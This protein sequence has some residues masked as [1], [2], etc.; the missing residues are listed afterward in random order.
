[1]SAPVVSIVTSVRDGA[2]TLETSL[3]SVLSQDL[4]EIEL[5]VVD[6]GSRDDSWPRLEAL[7]AR[8]PRVRPLRQDNRGLTLALARACDEARAPFIAR[9]DADDLSLPGRLRRQV[10]RLRARPERAFVS[11]WSRVLGPAD[12]LLLELR[13]PDDDERARQRLE[14]N[15]GP[16]GHGSVM[17]RAE[18][19]R[20]AGGYRAA[21]RYAQD[22]DLW[23]RLVDL[24]GLSYEPD[25][26][27]AFR[28]GLLS[29]SAERRSQQQRLRD[30]AHACRA[31][32]RSGGDE[33]ALLAEAERVSA[34]PPPARGRRD[35]GNAYF[36]GKCLLD[37]GDARAL[38]YLRLARRERPLAWRPLL[39]WL[40]A[41][42]RAARPPVASAGAP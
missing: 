17:F 24:G 25:F 42:L 9:H 6:D 14:Q 38:P 11:C 12:E 23:L 30:L 33:A 20:R 28:V 4:R 3:G 32:R 15:E 19:Y 40:F 35:P 2:A 16:P 39:A 29:L 26:L 8:D 27:Y 34:E 37:R 10:E 7:A 22:W 31:A 5:I 13:R 21:F 1:V 18:V 36:I 41:R